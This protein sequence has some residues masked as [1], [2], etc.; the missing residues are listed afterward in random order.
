MELLR[1]LLRK[2]CDNGEIQLAQVNGNLPPDA[3]IAALK[4][5]TAV[6][7]HCKLQWVY[8]RHTFQKILFISVILVAGIEEATLQEAFEKCKNIAKELE[9]LIRTFLKSI[10]VVMRSALAESN[11]A[12]VS[13][14]QITN[15]S[16]EACFGC[17]D[18]M[19]NFNYKGMS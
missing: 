2:P 3:R 19:M 1:I 12:T 8:M 14:A 7:N 6:F 11:K 15:G 16:I 17:L 5:L 4:L 9:A 10:L 13:V 18:A